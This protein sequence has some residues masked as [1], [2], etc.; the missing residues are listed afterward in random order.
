MVCGILVPWS[1]IECKPLALKAW[2]PNHWMAVE[3]PQGIFIFVN[4]N[5]GHQTSIKKFSEQSSLCASL[6]VGSREKFF[7]WHVFH[8]YLV[9]NKPHGSFIVCVCA[10]LVPCVWLFA[11]PWTIAHQTLLSMVFSRQEY[12]SGLPLPSPGNLPKPRDRTQVS[13]IAGRFFITWTPR[14]AHYYYY[15]AITIILHSP[16][17]FFNLLNFKQYLVN[18]NSNINKINISNMSTIYTF[19]FLYTH[20]LLKWHPS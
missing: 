13:C 6:R 9:Y 20:H 18:N 3:V 7:Q 14:E 5:N 11:T 19:F 4:V 15:L 1:E 8:E 17:I 2:S 10:Q 12:W 16:D